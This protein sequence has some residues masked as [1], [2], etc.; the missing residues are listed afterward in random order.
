MSV[1]AGDVPAPETRVR[2]WFAAGALARAEWSF[3]APLFVDA[4]LGLRARVTDDR[5][6]FAPDTTVYRVPV[7]ASTEGVGVGAHFF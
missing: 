1:A 2:P 6:Y 3:L 5:F 7:F 4:E